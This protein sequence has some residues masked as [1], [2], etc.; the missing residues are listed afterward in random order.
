MGENKRILEFSSSFIK[1]VHGGL[2]VSVLECQSKALGFTSRPDIFQIYTTSVP[3]ANSAMM[4]TL[5]ASC[6]WEDEMVRERT[7]HP[8]SY[9]EALKMKSLTLHTHGC[10]RASLRDCSSFPSLYK[11][12]QN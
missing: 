6:Q 11:K 2:V 1:W 4:S 3:L 10:H 8:P 12:T 7:V 5:N 9:A